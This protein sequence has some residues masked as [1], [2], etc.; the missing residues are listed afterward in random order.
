M[1]Q[2]DET[3]R[4]Y[5]SGSTEEA[6]AKMVRDYLKLDAASMN[7]FAL[8]LIHTLLYDEPERFFTLFEKALI[9]YFN[10]GRKTGNLLRLISD[11]GKLDLPENI[12]ALGP[13]PCCQAIRRFAQ[14]ATKSR[15]NSIIYQHFPLSYSTI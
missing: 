2:Q 9:S 6:L 12:R 10:S 14:T 7:A 8:P 5:I 4:G 13:S 11:A 3:K 1:T 15:N